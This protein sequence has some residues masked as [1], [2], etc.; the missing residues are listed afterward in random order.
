MADNRYF[1]VN[2][3]NANMTKIYGIVLNGEA[4]IVMSLDGT[5][6]M[7]KLPLGDTANHGILNNATELTNAEASAKKHGIEYS[8][9]A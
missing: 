2:I 9:P 5:K 6:A 1:E 8:E 4:G 3:P 7:F